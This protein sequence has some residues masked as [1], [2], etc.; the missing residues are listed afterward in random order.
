MKSSCIACQ[1]SGKLVDS[2]V[3]PKT[4]YKLDSDQL[5]VVGN[6]TR[7]IG[8]SANG[9]KGRFLCSKCESDLFQSYDDYAAIF[10]KKNRSEFKEVWVEGSE[11]VKFL[12][13]AK[14][15]ANKLILFFLSVLWR[16]DAMRRTYPES[17]NAQYAAQ[18]YDLVSQVNLG[19]YYFNLIQKLITKGISKVKDISVFILYL[20]N[21]HPNA[22]S[23]VSQI[24]KRR[25]DGAI[26]YVIHIGH[27]QGLIRLGSLP[28]QPTTEYMAM[29]E[30]KPVRILPVDFYETAAFRGLAEIVLK[31]A[32]LPVTNI[33]AF[34]KFLKSQKTL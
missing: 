26:T 15:D 1:S 2:H 24:Y 16:A 28:M 10:L 13:E 21:L 9:V 30:G 17:P 18:Q 12:E 31:K 3:I 22:S 19:D 14:G 11:D 8:R 33:E 20:E 25:F 32:N 5:V 7:K 4:F 29:G 34:A 27:F 23:S 6:D